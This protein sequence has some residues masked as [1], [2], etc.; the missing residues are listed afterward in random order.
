MP[1][2]FDKRN[3]I[4][5]FFLLNSQAKFITQRAMSKISTLNAKLDEI[6][7]SIS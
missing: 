7:H 3:M 5:N 2:I 4:G 1:L 6:T